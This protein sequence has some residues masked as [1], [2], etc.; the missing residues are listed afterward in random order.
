VSTKRKTTRRRKTTQAAGNADG[1]GRVSL[2]EQEG[3]LVLREP[4]LCR[5]GHEAF[6]R[7]L[8]NAAGRQKDIRAVRIC[9][10]SGTCRLEFAAGQVSAAEMANRFAEA[11]REAISA[12]MEGGGPGRDHGWT[13]LTVFPAG[14]AGSTWETTREGQGELRLRSP[15]LDKDLGLARRVARELSGAPGVASCR[16]TL[17]SRDLEIR[18]DPGVTS[19]GIVVS[20]AEDAFRRVLRPTLDRS[21]AEEPG[22]P[23]VVKGL[24]RAWYLALAG[25]SFTLT[26]V[27]LV[28]PG[29]PTVP[30]L[31]ATSYY[32]V[33]SSPRLNGL[34]LR[35]RYFGPILTD[36]EEWGGLRRVNKIKL[37]VLTLAVGIVT[38]VLVGPPLVL[39]LVMSA[40]ASAS[41][42]AI[43]RIPGIPPRARNSSSPGLAPSVA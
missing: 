16:A 38:L 25:G 32:L 3:V 20:A 10:A 35:S 11:V 34:L 4:E 31:L 41:V 43:M 26:L 1:E 40:V 37:I 27:G 24:R 33:R 9:L 19:A 5:P 42:Y 15:I 6:C 8:A 21:T 30:F 39:L 18:F 12:G 14:E 36:L 23:A 17:W 13:A 29:V 22:P 2:C 7:R 28:V